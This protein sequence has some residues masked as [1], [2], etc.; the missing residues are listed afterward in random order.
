MAGLLP[1]L[2][3]EQAPRS[4]QAGRLPFSGLRMSR[5]TSWM[6]IRSVT[7]IAPWAQL[8]RAL[9]AIQKEFCLS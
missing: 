9:S 1:G 4:E 7:T 8:V 6:L 2:N 3:S 5:L